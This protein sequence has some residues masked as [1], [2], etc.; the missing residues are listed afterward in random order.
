[1]IATENIAALPKYRTEVFDELAS[2]LD[3]WMNNTVDNTDGGF[4]GSVDNNN[5]PD[6]HAPKGVVLNSRILWSFSAAYNV[7]RNPAYLDIASRAYRYIVD[8]FVDRKY[9]GVYWSVDHKGAMLN[10]RKQIYGIAFCIYGLSEYYRATKEDMALHLAKNL[11]DHIEKYSFDRREGGYFEAFTQGWK[12]VDDL[13]L[14]EKDDNEKKTANTHLHIIEAYTNLYSVSP[15]DHLRE[16]IKH[17]LDIF[18]QHF[19]D[20]RTGHLHLFM[21]ERWNPQSSL[22]STVMISRHLA[23][24]KR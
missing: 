15:N 20:T 4:F 13:R 3:Y 11:F 6:T 8:H 19:I 9:G 14:S 10:G 5:V 7:D 22:I 16:T 1:M 2:I 12:P 23:F 17:L 21:D 24:A 18:D